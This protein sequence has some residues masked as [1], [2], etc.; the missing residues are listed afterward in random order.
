MLAPEQNL[1]I[2]IIIILLLLLLL[3]CRRLLNRRQQRLRRPPSATAKVSTIRPHNVCQRTCYRP[4][5]R[6]RRADIDGAAAASKNSGAIDD[7]HGSDSIDSSIITIL[8]SVSFES[9]RM[10][11]TGEPSQSSQGRRSKNSGHSGLGRTVQ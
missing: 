1:I 10:R 4:P 6:R 11:A 9:W 7:G 5:E 2:I 3:L 8:V